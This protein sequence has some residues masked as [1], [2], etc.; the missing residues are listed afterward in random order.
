M[1]ACVCCLRRGN[2]CAC[3]CRPEGCRAC[4]MCVEHCMCLLRSIRQ[5]LERLAAADPDA[6]LDDPSGPFGSRMPAGG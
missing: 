5:V 2:N 1:G 3:T 4:G 6:G